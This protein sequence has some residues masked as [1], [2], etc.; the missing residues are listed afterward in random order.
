MQHEQNQVISHHD[1]HLSFFVRKLVGT[2]LLFHLT[3]LIEY[4]VWGECE[5]GGA[6]ILA[7]KLVPSQSKTSRA[8][9]SEHA[10]LRS[11]RLLIAVSCC[12]LFYQLA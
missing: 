1:V 5:G 9:D 6:R 12:L 7:R 3:Q 11:D 10:H 4:G 8:D 2:L